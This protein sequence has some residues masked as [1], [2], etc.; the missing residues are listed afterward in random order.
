MQTSMMDDKQAALQI[1]LLPWREMSRQRKKTQFMASLAVTCAFSFFILLM[2]HFYYS[3]IHSSQLQINNILQNEISQGQTMLNEMSSQ[4]AESRAVI[5]QLHT[6]IDLYNE[7][8]QTVRFLSELT[9]L[10]PSNISLYKIKHV[11][12]DITLIGVAVSE[13]AV[14][15]FMKQ[16]GKSPYFNQ[17][18][19]S[20]ISMDSDKQG[21]QKNF[22]LNIVQKA[23]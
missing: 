1:N 5:L 4:E 2:F 18:V 13:E 12:D 15:N 14:T 6:I 17:P 16:I 8:F 9:S 7:S 19:L 23:N 21:A 10:V 22:Q 3:S 20:S 11:G